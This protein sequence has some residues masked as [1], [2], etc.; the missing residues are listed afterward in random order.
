M[1]QA[2]AET[3]LKALDRFVG[4]WTMTA[5]PPDGP[6]WPGGGRMRYEWIE[7]GAFLI[8]RWTIALPEAPDGTAING[9]AV[10][11]LAHVGSV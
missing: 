10:E 1:N 6:A 9:P 11:S 3:M 8:Q 4:E 5:G 7:G 2:T